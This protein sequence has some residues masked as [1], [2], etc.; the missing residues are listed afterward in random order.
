MT[1]SILSIVSAG[2]ARVEF[3]QMRFDSSIAALHP[4]RIAAVSKG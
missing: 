3:L 2:K 4:A 1:S